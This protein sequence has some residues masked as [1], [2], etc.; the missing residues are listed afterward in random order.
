MKTRIV[1]FILILLVSFY[2][3]NHFK[4]S[5]S[6]NDLWDLIPSKSSIILELEEPIIQYNKMFESSI[7]ENNLLEIKNH[8]EEFNFFLDNSLESFLNSNKVIIAYFKI[9]KFQL[10]PLYVT[11]K[12]T[13]DLDF[14][15]KK[16]KENGYDV[17]KRKFNSQTIYEFK[18]ENKNYTL[19][20]IENI[21]ILSKNSLLVEDAIRTKS[22]ED[23]K[24]KKNESS[25]TS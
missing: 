23:L 16:I 4:F 7:I 21:I 14:I 5:K 25:H 20:S 10:D 24:F 8:F 2:F 9:S 18:K 11:Y 12:G 3:F 1:F 17:N 15:F 22:N 6:K 13:L 19:C